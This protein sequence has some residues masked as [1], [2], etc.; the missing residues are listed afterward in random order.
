M[1]ISEPSKIT[2]PFA[3]SG[4]KNPIPAN[5]D[6]TT[7]KAGFDK[8]FP[9]RTMLPKASGGIPPS[10][11]DFNG[12]LYDIT[13]AIRYMQAG[14]KP[15]YDAALAAAIG[16]YPSG[17][18]LLGD[19]GVSVFQ[20]AVDGNATDPNSGGAGWTRPDLQVMEL[21]RRSY[22]EAGH[23]V[24]GTFQAGFTYVNASDVG[25]DLATG[26]GYT[27]PAGDV[28]AGTDPASGWF[29]DK[30]GALL[31]S[32]IGFNAAHYGLSESNTGLQN[33][34]AM[35]A[36]SA[37]VMSAGGG[38]VFFP[39]GEYTVGAQN[40]AGVAGKG[41]AYDYEKMFEVSGLTKPLSVYFDGVKF[42]FESGLR[43]GSFD[44]VTGA[45]IS[46]TLPY[47]NKDSRAQTGFVINV[48]NCPMVAL[49]GSL[50]IDG[51]DSTR[52]IG[53][54]WGDKGRQLIEY[55]L[56]IAHCKIYAINGSFKL[57]HLCLDGLYLGNKAEDDCAGSVTGVV[58]LYNGRQGVSV[59]G[60]RNITFNSCSFGLTGFGVVDSAPAAAVD[61]E[62][63][64]YPLR[65]VVFN[66]CRLFKTKGGAFTADDFNIRGA[67]FNDC[68]IENDTNASIH[69]KVS[70]TKFNRCV[71]RGMI[72]A[73]QPGTNVNQ[74]NVGL[75]NVNAYPELNNCDLY[76]TMEDGTHA[77][78]YPRLT[79]SLLAKVN[80]CTAFVNLD[81]TSNL[82]IWADTSRVNGLRIVLSGA[83]QEV[84]SLFAAFRN[85]K[86]LKDIYVENNTTV[87]GGTDPAVTARIESG[88]PSI[89]GPTENLFIEK[90]DNG[91]ENILWDNS[92]RS[93]G[94]RAG[95]YIDNYITSYADE[96][97]GILPASRRLGLAKRGYP[98]VGLYKPQMISSNPSIPTSGNY[99]RGDIII[100]SDPSAGGAFGWMC[101]TTG[102]AGSTAVFKIITNIGA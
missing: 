29:V 33:C 83:V 58:S 37:A 3:E 78:G 47:Y 11:M 99:V 93:A 31:S 44:P 72:S 46:P 79:T 36:L 88:G 32:Q 14:G 59:C 49:Y 74:G 73:C 57:H 85:H 7:G 76:N 25:I 24:V 53:G 52:I 34:K 67:V 15:T 28:A 86:G 62:P 68:I 5:S 26:K 13:S 20:N 54:L 69:S 42:K 16:G 2:V 43:Y 10:G 48:E 84:N 77:Y 8:G 9:E 63:E 94:G 51:R 56:R 91:F 38:V 27:G 102:A 23:N 95:F 98:S 21:Y 40:I 82:A 22:A 101:T 50:E 66:N 92:N 39:P 97:S 70:N 75:D 18:V 90:S 65:G 61:L 96:G 60:G 35:Q 17:A 12:I 45:A 19:D 89:A 87:T 100:N 4:L 6:N 1:G 64:L 80:N 30:S 81:G 41:Y 55:G 71:I